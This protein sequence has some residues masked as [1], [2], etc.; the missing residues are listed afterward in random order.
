MWNSFSA[1]VLGIWQHVSHL[2]NPLRPTPDLSPDSGRYQG[3]KCPGRSQKPK[4]HCKAEQLAQ[5]IVCA[6]QDFVYQI[7]NPSV[8][9]DKTNRLYYEPGEK[10]Y[11]RE[12]IAYQVLG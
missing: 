7:G 5:G 8:T 9:T 1:I 3:L 6:L 11:M 12:T 2:L 10:S 4:G